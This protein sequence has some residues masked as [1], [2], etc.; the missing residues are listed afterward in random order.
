MDHEATKVHK[1]IKED[2]VIMGHEEI[3][4][5]RGR[6]A[7]REEKEDQAIKDSKVRVAGLAIKDP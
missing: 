3:T 5:R 4:E 2:V 7:K 6:K 1:E